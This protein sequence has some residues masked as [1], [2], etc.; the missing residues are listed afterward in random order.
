MSLEDIALKTFKRK[1]GVL[2]ESGPRRV[3]T[4]LGVEIEN[5]GHSE[6]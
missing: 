6:G 5:P 1:L 2:V 4:Q 3:E